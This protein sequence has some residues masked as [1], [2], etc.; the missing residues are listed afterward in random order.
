MFIFANTAVFVSAG[1]LVFIYYYIYRNLR[2]HDK[3]S[4]H[5]R[6]N[7]EQKKRVKQEDKITIS[8]V[9]IVISFLLCALPSFVMIYIINLCHT[10]SRMLIHWLRDLL[11]LLFLLNSATNQFLYA[12]R[13]RPFRKVFR[14]I[15]ARQWFVRRFERGRIHQKSPQVNEQTNQGMGGSR[16]GNAK[17]ERMAQCW[18]EMKPDEVQ[19]LALKVIGREG[20]TF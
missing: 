10:C 18:K 8:L 12:W 20:R 7:S 15:P 19:V 2:Q 17:R 5:I 3:N 9:L 13:M 1:V 6:S 16:S 4:K 14:I 11:C